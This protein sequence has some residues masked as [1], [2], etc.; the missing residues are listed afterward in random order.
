MDTARWGWLFSV[1]P[2]IRSAGCTYLELLEA[3]ALWDEKIVLPYGER[4][5]IVAPTHLVN[6]PAS[7]AMRRAN[8]SWLVRCAR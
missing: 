6:T 1:W 5:C 4:I 2:P 3:R 8:A 7:V